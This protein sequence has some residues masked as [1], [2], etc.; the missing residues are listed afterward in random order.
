MDT[1]TRYIM[2]AGLALLTGIVLGTGLGL[3]LAHNQEHGPVASYETWLMTRPNV[4][5]ISPKMRKTR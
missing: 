2:F 5:A 4:Q 3:L 1:D